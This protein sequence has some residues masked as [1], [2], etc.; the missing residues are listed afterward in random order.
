[1]HVE[2][3]VH[4]IV[5]PQDHHSTDRP[6]QQIVEEEV[7]EHRHDYRQRPE[8]R[9]QESGRHHLRVGDAEPQ[10]DP[11]EQKSAETVA[12]PGFEPGEIPGREPQRPSGDHQ[13]QK[14]ADGGGDPVEKKFIHESV[15]L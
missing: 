14:S 6:R 13:Q 5:G 12:R 11:S 2:G 15:P 10:R 9:L 7:G 1:M 4:Q 3:L 8:Q